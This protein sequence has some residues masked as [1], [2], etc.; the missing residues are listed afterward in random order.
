[1]FILNL[2]TLSVYVL[3]ICIL[4]DAYMCVY[5]NLY[6]KAISFILLSFICTTY[7]MNTN[8][9]TNLICS[10]Y[11]CKFKAFDTK[12]PYT[13]VYSNRSLTSS[14]SIHTQNGSEL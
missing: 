7:D 5:T 11:K 2:G 14:R 1:M 13:Q 3:N 9:Y 8:I 12:L 4:H 6:S 10:A